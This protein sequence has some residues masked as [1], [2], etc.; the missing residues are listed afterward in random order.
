MS[1]SVNE[2]S[3]QYRHVSFIGLAYLV[4]AKRSTFASFKLFFD[5]QD[6]QSK[7]S[8]GF[9]SGWWRSKDF[10]I[11][12]I[13]CQLKAPWFS[14]SPTHAFIGSLTPIM[15]LLGPSRPLMRLLGMII[16]RS[17]WSRSRSKFDCH[18]WLQNHRR[19][20]KNQRFH[21]TKPIFGPSNIPN[22]MRDIIIPCMR[23]KQSCQRI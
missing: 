9:N 22:H 2:E 14:L 5:E 16:S 11:L 17:A 19:L 10:C 13:T 6:L 23:R 8:P 7:L 18:A 21:A 20:Q 12:Q 1:E 3:L 4:S 15:R